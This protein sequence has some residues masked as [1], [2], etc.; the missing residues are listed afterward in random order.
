M[1]KPTEI[2]S[3]GLR[4]NVGDVL[5]RVSYGNEE[6]LVCVHGKPAAR[7]V[8]VRAEAEERPAKPAKVKKSD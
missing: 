3:E 2:T 6:F 4:R 5:K 8:P 1:V 7:I